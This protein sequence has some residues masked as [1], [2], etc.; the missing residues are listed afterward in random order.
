MWHGPAVVMSIVGIVTAVEVNEF[1]V[2]AGVVDGFPT[3]TNNTF[4]INKYHSITCTCTKI[5]LHNNYMY[6]IISYY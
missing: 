5:F 2:R 6:G 4:I 1:S 3:V